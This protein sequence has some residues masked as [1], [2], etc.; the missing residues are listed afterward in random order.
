[1]KVLEAYEEN[2]FSK[3]S[4]FYQFLEI[5]SDQ[6][7]SE[8]LRNQVKENIYSLYK[9]NSQVTDFFSSEKITLEKL[10]ENSKAKGLK[11]E[12][13]NIQKEITSN[14]F[15]TNSYSLKISDGKE[16]MQKKVTQKVYFYPEEK[17]FGSKKKEVWIILL[18]DF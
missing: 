7:S 2:S 5:Y 4:D 12:V 13:K 14:N 17:S 15:W 18:G 10:L 1:M 11:F 16:I 8:T 9:N 6:N 3:V